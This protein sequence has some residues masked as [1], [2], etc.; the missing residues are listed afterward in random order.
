MERSLR[1]V[2]LLEKTWGRFYGWVDRLD[3]VARWVVDQ[4]WD[5]SYKKII[6]LDLI[7]ISRFIGSK[8]SE[9]YD[10]YRRLKRPYRIPRIPSLTTAL[11]VLGCIRSK[12]VRAAFLL[13]VDAGLRLVEIKRLRWSDVDLEQGRLVIEQGSKRTEGSILPMSERLK[14]ALVELKASTGGKAD[15]FV[16]TIDGRCIHRCISRARRKCG[17]PD[18]EHV[19]LKNLRHLYATTLYQ[20]TR[21]IALVQRMMRHRLITTTARY[22][23]L[24]TSRN[25]YESRAVPAGDKDTILKLLEDGWELLREIKGWVYFRRLK[26]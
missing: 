18:A 8:P 19:N 10:L 24:S 7:R 3:E 9:L 14:Q 1:V 16:I 21:D 5:A 17:F 23:H 26:E 22:V 4:G 20:R 6:L 2:G 25:T 11:A 13:A 15:D 12:Q